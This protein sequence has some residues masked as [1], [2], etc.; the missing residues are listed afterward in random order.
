MATCPEFLK[1]VVAAAVP[2]TADP[3]ETVIL[4][5]KYA[6]DTGITDIEATDYRTIHVIFEAKSE[7]VLP[8]PEQLAKYSISKDIRCPGTC[9]MRFRKCRTRHGM[10]TVTFTGLDRRSYREG[11]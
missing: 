3:E 5:Q 2:V 10:E 8:G 6:A 1:A 11:P 4:N 9:M 7:W